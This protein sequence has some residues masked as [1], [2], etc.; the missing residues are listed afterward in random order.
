MLERKKIVCLPSR[1]LLRLVLVWT[2]ASEGHTAESL[3]LRIQIYRK[4]NKSQLTIFLCQ[5]MSDI[6][7]TSLGTYRIF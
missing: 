6:L 4:T 2:L 5:G 3:Y 1:A 7:K